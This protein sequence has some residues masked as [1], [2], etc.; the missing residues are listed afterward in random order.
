MTT[1]D[2]LKSLQKR[3][4]ES[5]GPDAELDLA[6]ADAFGRPA[7][8]VGGDYVAERFTTD[9]DDLGACV[10]LMREVLPWWRKDSTQL[11]VF[12]VYVWHPDRYTTTNTSDQHALE[13]HA[14]LLAII[15]AR[16]A[17]IAEEEAKEKADV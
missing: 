11:E 13:T 4:R 8:W 7:I 5:T 9:P 12:K 6:I 2:T 3:T 15:A 1:I 14:T 10:A 16:I 17:V